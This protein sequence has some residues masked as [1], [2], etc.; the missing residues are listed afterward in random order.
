MPAT[1]L[2]SVHEPVTILNWDGS[3]IDREIKNR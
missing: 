3:E 2:L 1:I